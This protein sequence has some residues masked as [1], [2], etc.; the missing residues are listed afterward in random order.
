LILKDGTLFYLKGNDLKEVRFPK[1]ENFEKKFKWKKMN[2][3]TH[4]PKKCPKV[5][6]LLQGERLSR[7]AIW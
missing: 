6:S 2:F 7:L 3:V 1:L 5:F 4:L